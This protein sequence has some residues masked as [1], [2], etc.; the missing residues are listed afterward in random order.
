MK[1]QIIAM[2]FLSLLFS[3]CASKQEVIFKDRLICAEQVIIDRPK[4]TLRVKKAD[5][6]V[7]LAF[8]EALDS[9]FLFYE[10][11][12]NQNNKLCEELK[13]DENIK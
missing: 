8:K 4:A 7:A 2:I 13:N 3:A 6:N 9:S 10:N 1:I 12:V 11:Q 5:T